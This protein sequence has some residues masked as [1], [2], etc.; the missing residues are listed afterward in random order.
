MNQPG[1]E[2][3]SLFPF[4]VPSLEKEREVSQY[5]PNFPQNYLNNNLLKLL[6]KLTAFFVRNKA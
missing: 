1:E 3:K 5:G 4:R 6:C 2:V